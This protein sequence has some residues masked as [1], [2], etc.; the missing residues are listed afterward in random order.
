MTVQH[1]ET[2]MLE[3]MA[4]WCVED[5]LSIFSDRVTRLRSM[6]RC[7]SRLQ[8]PPA[9]ALHGRPQPPPA[10]VRVGVPLHTPHKRAR[11]PCAA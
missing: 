11:P 4:E 1:L 7:D 10:P 9:P 8:P 6:F 2:T 3:V 5:P